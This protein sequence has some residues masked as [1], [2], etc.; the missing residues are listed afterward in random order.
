MY[1]KK[2]DELIASNAKLAELLGKKEEP[3]EEKKCCNTVVWVLAIIGA[4]AAV[5]AI[6]YA[7][8]RYMNQ[9]SLDDFDFEDD[10]FEDDFE[11]EIEE[12]AEEEAEEEPTEE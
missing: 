2:I 7:V 11:E 4:I 3:V 10:D 8:Y 1:M 5:A 9:E 12:E 6:A